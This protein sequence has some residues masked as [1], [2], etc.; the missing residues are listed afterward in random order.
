M[1]APDAGAMNGGDMMANDTMSTTNTTITT[2]T[3][4]NA[5]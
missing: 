4:G 3:T 5:M 1:T 2:N